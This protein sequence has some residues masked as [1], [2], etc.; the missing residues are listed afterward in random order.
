MARK[1]KISRLS[2]VKERVVY[3]D[4]YRRFTTRDKAVSEEYWKYREAVVK[5]K[6]KI[7]DLKIEA[8][9]YS[10]GETSWFPSIQ[11]PQE[12][13]RAGKISAALQKAIRGIPVSRHDSKIEITMTAKTYHGKI[14]KRKLS[15]YHYNSKKL[16]D[17]TIGGI[18]NNLF[19]EY[20]DRPAYPVKIVKGWRRRQ[21]M[22]RETE[23]RRQLYD[24]TFNIKA[25]VETR[26]QGAKKKRKKK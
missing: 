4:A 5:G 8:L 23:K 9:S 11:V 16:A 18:I 10:E 12:G 3:R 20:G 19:Y 2:G 26:K 24:V 22:K 6:K 25:E 14:V 17:H 15:F 7:Q 13:Q 1:P 21:T